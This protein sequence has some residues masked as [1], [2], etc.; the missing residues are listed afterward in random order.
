M[1]IASQLTDVEIY[2]PDENKMDWRKAEPNFFEAA[3]VTLLDAQSWSYAAAD[4][5]H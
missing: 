5:R 2:R 4:G 3:L 1:Q